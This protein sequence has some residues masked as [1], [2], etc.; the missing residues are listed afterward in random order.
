MRKVA[1]QKRTTTNHPLAIKAHRTLQNIVDEFSE[2]IHREAMK[3]PLYRLTFEQ[4]GLKGPT[5]AYLLGHDGWALKTLPRE[6]LIFRFQMTGRRRYKGRK[7]RSKLLI[8]LAMSVILN[9]HPRYHEVYRR[10]F[11][12]FE[13]EG[14]NRKK[15]YWKAILRVAERILRDLHSLAKNTKQTPDT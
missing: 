6:K 14:N 12:K 8:M 4:L 9:K 7:T 10:Y 1:K 3:L 5:L 13:A 11:E 15:A 2:E